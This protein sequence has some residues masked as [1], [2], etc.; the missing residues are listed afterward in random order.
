M[1]LTNQNTL[2]EKT[3]KFK[4]EKSGQIRMEKVKRTMKSG[5]G[6]VNGFSMLYAKLI[7]FCTMTISLKFQKKYQSV[8]AG[9]ADRNLKLYLLIMLPSTKGAFAPEEH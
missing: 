3:F 5:F 4:S 1:F 6:S 2:F 9:G 7:L 8:T